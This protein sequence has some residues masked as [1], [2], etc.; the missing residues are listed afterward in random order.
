MPPLEEKRC[1]ICQKVFCCVDCRKAH[2]TKRHSELNHDCPI[3]MVQKLALPKCYENSELLYHI[4]I[5]H[6]PLICTLCGEEY[7]KYKDLVQAEKCTWWMERSQHL[8][9]RSIPF[10]K[11]LPVLDT[12]S[13]LNDIQKHSES[14]IKRLSV[15]NERNRGFGNFTS[16][17][18]LSRNTSTPMHIACAN[19]TNYPQFKTP[20]V[21]NFSLKTPNT[22]TP[23]SSMSSTYYDAYS[24]PTR[25]DLEKDDTKGTTRSAYLTGLSSLSKSQLLDDNFKL[26][27]IIRTPSACH[28]SEYQKSSATRKLEVMREAEE[29]NLSE[30]DMELTEIQGAIIDSNPT[31]EESSESLSKISRISERRESIKKVRFSDQFL[32]KTET[33]SSVGY[34]VTENEIFFEARESISE[35]AVGN[36]EENPPQEDV[37]VKSKGDSNADA[38]TTENLSNGNAAH[39]ISCRSG[40]SRVVMMLLLENNGSLNTTD[41]VPLIDSS[42]KK[43]EQTAA[44]ELN[45][46]NRTD[47]TSSKHM[48]TI[49][50]SDRYVSVSAVERTT[51]HNSA[52]SMFGIPR[53]LSTS[54][55]ETGSKG[56]FSAVARAVKC[57]IKNLSGSS[58]PSSASRRTAVQNENA[59]P[60]SS[61]SLPSTSLG[62]VLTDATSSV[63]NR[64]GKRSRE[65]IESPPARSSAN[66]GPQYETTNSP[67]TKKHRTWVKIKCREPI[68]R[69]RG[70]PSEN[71][72]AANPVSTKSASS[73]T[74]S[75]QQ[76]P[77]KVA[78]PLLPIP[79]RA[80]QSTQTE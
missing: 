34:N 59:D 3:C 69:M 70:N 39:P 30:A 7:K 64:P 14:D 15:D 10:P 80:H 77:L 29:P 73:E 71:D 19:K 23:A 44:I 76:G 53:I 55:E 11:S 43:L 46:M 12:P 58:V 51:G 49:T 8:L 26:L 16:P 65:L 60:A 33:S 72:Q 45:A 24:L 75:F 38:K 32:A 36:Q 6:L 62:N 31:D 25:D 35:I 42:L 4:A 18:E 74:Q 78:D 67:A 22:Q 47:A 41:L 79:P 17:P 1:R 48:R 52:L 66:L 40:Q 21:P 5:T 57:A 9:R 27:D 20:N 56:I 54:N 37:N 28:N 61:I 50:S 63:L 2:Q 13:P 68:A